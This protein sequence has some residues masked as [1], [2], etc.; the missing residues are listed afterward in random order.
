MPW[1]SIIPA[2]V[3]IL[4]LLTFLAALNILGFTNCTEWKFLQ[5]APMKD[6]RVIGAFKNIV[7]LQAQDGSTYCNKHNGWERCVADT[8]LVSHQDV[9]AW[10]NPWFNTIP[11]EAGAVQL[12]LAGDFYLGQTHFALLD[13]G[14]IWSCPSNF[15]LETE[16]IIQSGAVI[17]LIIPIVIGAGCF[18][19]FLNIFAE[20]GSPTLWGF[21]GRGT[22]IK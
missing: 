17:G 5:S 12:T 2:G 20:Y 16:H 1:Y 14:Q 9:P 3:G 6:M 7:Y 19:W 22:K 8:W 21:R 10:F 15:K 4:M 13:D 11:V 18:L